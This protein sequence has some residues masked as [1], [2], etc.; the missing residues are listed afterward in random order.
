[1]SY[2]MHLLLNLAT[3]LL[4]KTP[5]AVDESEADLVSRDLTEVIEPALQRLRDLAADFRRQP[6]SPTHTHQFERQLQETLR[7][8][9]RSIVQHTYNHL[10]PL[11]DVQA[12]A[13]HVHF[14]ADLY[15][16]LNAKTPQNAWT[17]FGQ[18]RLWRVGYRP[19]DKSGDPTIFPLALSL[20]L[21]QGASPALAERMAYF[22]GAPGMT[23]GQTLQRLKQDHGVGWGVKKLRQV[24]D[25]VSQALTA[26]RHETQVEK[27][28]ELLRQASATTG[29][30]KPVLSVGRD[31]ITLGMRIKRGN[32][33]EVATTGTVS[34]L[35][36]RGRRLGTVYLAYTP[37]A[38]QVTMTRELTRLL[39]DVLQRWQGSLPRLCY[40]T[41]AGDNETTYYDKVLARMKHPCT[42]AQLNWIR[43][44]DYYHASERIWT[45]ADLLFGKGQQ[46]VAWA[47]KM[48]KW[49]LKPGGVNRVLHSAAALRDQYGL[50][51]TKRAGFQKAYRYLRVRMKY[52]QYAAY[53]RVG[54]PLGSGVTEAAC[55]TVYTQRLKLSGMRW[56]K[57][58]A[59]TILNLR[60]LQLSGVWDR[61][62]ARVLKEYS[63]PKVGD[64]RVSAKNRGQKAA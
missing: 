52:M 7:E 55:K 16:R 41:D 48:Q 61:A 33:F 62:Y 37:E 28:L 57:A 10:E 6:V 9:G 21:V 63:E 32:V 38:Q 59:Q 26:Q 51:G 53:R 46:S 12:L 25:A 42:G 44:V 30:H 14:E 56:K 4:P 35:D 17:L 47:R 1:M 13:K 64:Q 23:Q 24:S 11:A 54:V 36:R 15:T 31:G 8:L 39:R 50:Q 29:R 19:T 3:I 43:V 5:A 34:V 58:G 60:V 45:L 27:L 22:L 40:V 2:S 49:L 20:G 18:I